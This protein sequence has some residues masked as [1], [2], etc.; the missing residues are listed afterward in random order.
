MNKTVKKVLIGLGITLGV[1]AI[2]CAVLALAFREKFVLLSIDE[3]GD[4]DE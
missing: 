2:G 3:D 1:S 4:Y